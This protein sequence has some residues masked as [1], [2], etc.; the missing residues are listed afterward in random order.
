LKVSGLR[1]QNPHAL[2]HAFA[3]NAL[4]LKLDLPSISRA[5]GHASLQITLDVYAREK[6]DIQNAATKGLADYFLNEC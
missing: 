4:T 2:R 1:H 3:I 5:L 6:T